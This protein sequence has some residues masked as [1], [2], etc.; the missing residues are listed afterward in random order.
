MTIYLKP[1]TRII[2]IYIYM[3]LNL[4]IHVYI[5]I[6]IGG[7]ICNQAPLYFSFGLHWPLAQTPNFDFLNISHDGSYGTIVDLP[8]HE[9]L[10]FMVYKCR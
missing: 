2:S 10:I 3:Y 5:Y 6:D 8:I 4:Y 9:W 7:N 1:Q